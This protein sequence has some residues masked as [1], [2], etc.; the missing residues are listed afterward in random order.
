MPRYGSRWARPAPRSTARSQRGRRAAGAVL[1]AYVLN[2]ALNSA[3]VVWMMY[4]YFRSSPV[5]IEEAALT[6]GCNDWKT[7]FTVALPTVVPGIIA[8][9][10]FCIMFSWNDFLYAMFLT[11]AETKPTTE[12]GLLPAF[13]VTAR[14]D[15]M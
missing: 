9:A 5:S 12:R 10:I 2:T 8:S 6:D 15:T 3:F 13:P 4:A 1:V 11:R 7:F 14:A